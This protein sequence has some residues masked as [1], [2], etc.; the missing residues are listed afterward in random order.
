METVSSRGGQRR[1]PSGSRVNQRRRARRR[2]RRIKKAL[3]VLLLLVVCFLF[4]QSVLL[5][6]VK[7]HDNGKILEQ[8]YIGNLDVGGMT[9][10]EAE[11]KLKKRLSEA[12]KTELKLK[13]DG[14]ESAVVT[15]K[16]LGIS[17]D[18]KKLAKKAYEYGRTGSLFQRFKAIRRSK[19]K[20]LEIA[21]EFTFSEKKA[22][23]VL[24]KKTKELFDSPVNASIKHENDK[25]TIVKG[26]SG[27][28]LDAKKT[29]SKI[30]KYLN[31][32]WD[33]KNGSITVS[34]KKSKPEIQESDL[35]EVK[36]LLG[37]YQTYYG[38]ATSGS[39]TNIEAGATHVNGSI[40]MPG[41]EFSAN[42]VMEPYTE[43]E[44]YTSSGSYENG[45]L[46][47][48]MGGGICQVSS[49]LYNALLFA[50]VEITER[51][52]HSMLVDYVEPSMDAAIAD[53][54]KDLKFVNNYDVPIYIEAKTENGY[55]TFN[56]YGKETRSADRELEFI[57]E[58][59]D[60]EEPEGL[61]FVATE[62][63]AG[64]YEVVSGSRTGASAQLWKV[65]KENGK[66]I[67]REVI[68]TSNYASAKTTIGVGTT[69]DDATWKSQIQSAIASQD[70]A[71][72]K[73]AVYGGSADSYSS[74]DDSDSYSDQDDE[75]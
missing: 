37:T 7:R 6:Y 69:T 65:V 24:V 21:E 56:I 15:G 11:K 4:V 23:K 71:Q 25:I 35:K 46:V 59:L 63:S 54:V 72:V 61:R 55:L 8:T 43:E 45:M 33:G 31:Q 44:G 38:D 68:N 3:K 27:T 60:T 30:E 48:T 70:E 75:E 22:K 64:T 26:K 50:E 12:K 58:T 67:S 32:K 66:E 5:I 52:P 40:V 53:D 73:A 2:K 13:A 29:L 17:S 20:K 14:K 18:A 51:M 62:D 47:Q 42:E 34:S 39:A 49:T 57:S 16:E 74:D 28:T 1:A 36:D 9:Q 19:K 41:E 10:K